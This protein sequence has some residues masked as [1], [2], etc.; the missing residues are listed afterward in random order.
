MNVIQRVDGFGYGSSNNKT[1]GQEEMEGK[2][3]QMG[4]PPAVDEA[5]PFS[6][7]GHSFTI[8][9]HALDA[10]VLGWT[11]ILSGAGDFSNV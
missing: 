8:T 9:M 4:A 10:N 3:A 2:C 11:M 5:L 1:E 7:E 6:K